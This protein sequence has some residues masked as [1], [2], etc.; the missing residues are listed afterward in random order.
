VGPTADVTP[1]GGQVHN[2]Q[3]QPSWTPSREAI[4][5]SRIVEFAR[6]LVDRSITSLEDATD[7]HE[8]QAWAS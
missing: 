8:I 5:G 1:E 3:P 6:W 4:E 2:D 7:F